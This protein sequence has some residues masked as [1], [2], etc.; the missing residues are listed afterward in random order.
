MTKLL[1]FFLANK[2]ATLTQVKAIYSQLYFQTS[3][4]VSQL[5]R[6]IG[7]AVFGGIALLVILI[8]GSK[9][10]THEDGNAYCRVLPR[11]AVCGMCAVSKPTVCKVDFTDSTSEKNGHF[12]KLAICTMDSS[13]MKKTTADSKAIGRKPGS[14][15]DLLG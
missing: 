5:V 6:N 11:M 8:L 14:F 12:V 3:I 4:S 15:R 7:I 9:A 10:S 13:I 1:V 2:V